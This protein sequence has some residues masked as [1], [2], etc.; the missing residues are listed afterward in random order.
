MLLGHVASLHRYPVKSLV[1]EDLAVADVDSRGLVGDRTWAVRTPDG[2]LGSGKTSTRFRR[3]EGLLSLRARYVDGPAPL[4]GF[5]DGTELAADDPA[6]AAQLTALLGRELR[7]DTEGDVPHHDD[8]PVHLVTAT[9]LRHCA[10]Q[11]GRP[12]DVARCRPNL[13]LDTG[14]DQPGSA[15]GFP[16]DDW[17]GRQVAIGDEVVIGLEDGMPRCVMVDMAQPAAGLSGEL[18]LLRLLGAVHDVE[19]GLR[20]HVVRTGRLRVGDAVRLLEVG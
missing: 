9:A 2:G 1:G 6:A 8:S 4:I 13:V 5:P 15:T 11:L 18:G 12:V 17:R 16:E 14:D 3:V 20:A 19:L 10:D 7:L